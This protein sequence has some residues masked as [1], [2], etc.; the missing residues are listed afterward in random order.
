MAPKVI[1]FPSIFELLLDESEKVVKFM[2]PTPKVPTVGA[3]W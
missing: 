1:S 3:T 2:I